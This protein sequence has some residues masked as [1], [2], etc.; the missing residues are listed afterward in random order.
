MKEI[1]ISP[2]KDDNSRFFNEARF[3]VSV[4]VVQMMNTL[5]EAYSPP[6]FN[7]VYFDLYLRLLD[8]MKE[9]RMVLN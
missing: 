1:K 9:N 3:Q 6:T 7:H 2:A 4:L 8:V 5:L